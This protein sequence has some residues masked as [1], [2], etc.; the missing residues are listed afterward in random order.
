MQRQEWPEKGIVFVVET[1]NEI[2]W[3]TRKLDA[4]YKHTQFK[5]RDGARYRELDASTHYPPSNKKLVWLGTEPL[6]EV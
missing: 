6:L 2:Y 1:Q 4:T 5:Y 3:S